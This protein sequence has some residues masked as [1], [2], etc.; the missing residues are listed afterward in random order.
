MAAS[1]PSLPFPFGPQIPLTP[2]PDYQ[3]FSLPGG[4][5]PLSPTL[6][7]SF[8]RETYGHGNGLLGNSLSGGPGGVAGSL[9]GVGPQSEMTASQRSVP[10]TVNAGMNGGPKHA[11]PPPQPPLPSLVQRQQSGQQGGIKVEQTT[12]PPTSTV[13]TTTASPSITA[14]HRPVTSGATTTG[15]ASTRPTAEAVAAASSEGGTLSASDPHY[16]AIASRIAAYYHQRCQAVA[17]LQHQRY[18]AWA[19]MQRQKSQEMTQAAMLVVAWYIR[20]RIQRRRRRK[21]RQFRRGLAAKAAGED[22]KIRVAEGGGRRARRSSAAGRTGRP[23]TKGEA[24]RKWVLQVPELDDAVSPNTP[25]A[26]D[27]PADPDEVA[28]DIDRDTLSDN[29]TRLYNVADNL[30]KSQLA[31]INVPMMG[32]L[33][34]DASESESESESDDDE[35]AEG[36]DEGEDGDDLYDDS[37]PVGLG[38]HSVEDDSMVDYEE[39]GAPI[40]AVAVGVEAMIKDA[41]APATAARAGPGAGAATQPAGKRGHSDENDVKNDLDDDDDDDFDDDEEF[42]EEDDC[43]DGQDG[44]DPQV[45]ELGHDGTGA[46]GGSSGRRRETSSFL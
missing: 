19:N 26:R 12:A 40:E 35:E 3:S 44:A 38:A 20:D 27:R 7:K 13:T 36:D 42:E 6:L 23:V 5:T 17:N 28:F 32:T 4:P 22:N 34:F 21:K 43:D 2:P 14:T 39:R 33:S 16:L 9:K 29:D 18:L 10:G 8:T 25:G 30:I 24:V 31:R 37:K 45:S 46:G 11:F 41:T 15:A 1:M